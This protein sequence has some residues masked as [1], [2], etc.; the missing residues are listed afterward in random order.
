V[1]T[2]TE[3]QNISFVALYISESRL[4]I[5]KNLKCLLEYM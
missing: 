3:Y 2:I 4:L 1:K 5:H